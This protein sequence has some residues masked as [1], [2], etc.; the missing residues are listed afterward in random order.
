MALGRNVVAEHVR[1]SRVFRNPVFSR[2]FVIVEPNIRN[3]IGRCYGAENGACGTF[4]PS[5]G[6]PMTPYE[7]GA[8]KPGDGQSR[9]L[10]P[11]SPRGCVWRTLRA[12]S[13]GAPEANREAAGRRSIPAAGANGNQRR[14]PGPRVRKRI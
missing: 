7:I 10:G 6:S 14:F 11:M 9:L 8:R 12:S 2:V 5:Q 4:G 3:I 13:D 1:W